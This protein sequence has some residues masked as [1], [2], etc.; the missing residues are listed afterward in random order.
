[1][2]AANNEIELFVQEML[3]TR[4]DV[5]E[6]KL[7]EQATLK[8]LGLDSLG[9]VE[10][11]LTIKKRYGVQFIAGEIGVE[12]TVTDVADLTRQKLGELEAAAS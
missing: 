1:M 11:S 6:A 2:T 7:T 9:G 10:L 4:F 3:R 8:S 5:P 12:F